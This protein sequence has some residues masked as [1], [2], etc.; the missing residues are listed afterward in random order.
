VTVG[1]FRASGL[2]TPT[3][4]IENQTTGGNV[5]AY[6]TYTPTE[7]FE[8]FPLNCTS[9]SKARAFCQSKGEDLPSEA[10]L[11]YAAGAMQGNLYVWGDDPPACSDA[12]FARL[13]GQ[14]QLP[15][16]NCPG[17]WVAPPGS[18]ARDALTVPGG[19]VVDLAGNLSELAV[20]D[21]NLQSEACW[22]TGVFHDPVCR[23]P[24]ADPATAAAHTMV[25]GNWFSPDDWLRAASRGYVLDTPPVGD[26]TPLKVGFRCAR[27]GS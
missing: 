4:P 10:E 19:V 1:T 12:M 9:W 23:T 22:G 15:E 14:S 27:G 20:D 2:A 25:G 21:W 11:Q 5:P 26:Q 13:R 6:C 16:E 7:V 3:D 17:L 24:S 18:G 8:T